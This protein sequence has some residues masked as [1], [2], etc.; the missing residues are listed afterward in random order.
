[1]AELWETLVSHAHRLALRPPAKRSATDA[2][3][4]RLDAL[5]GGDLNAIERAHDHCLICYAEQEQLAW[6][7]AASWLLQLQLRLFQHESERQAPH[8]AARRRRIAERRGAAAEAGAR[9]TVARTAGRSAIAEPALVEQ[10]VQRAAGLAW[11]DAAATT[12][13]TLRALSGWLD[14]EVRDELAACLPDDL[15]ASLRAAAPSRPG[16][17]AELHHRVATDT[18]GDASGHDVAIG[19]AAVLAAL[20]DSLPPPLVASLADALPDDLSALLSTGG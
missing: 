9:A 11:Q 19:C 6:L 5:A 10:V 17:L 14:A 7:R 8:I 12:R 18:G 2:M 20:G 13:A 16:G 15:A 1:M 3:I 4:T